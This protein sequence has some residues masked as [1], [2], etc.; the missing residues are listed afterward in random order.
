M[1]KAAGLGDDG[2]MG[3]E[4]FGAGDL[5]GALALHRRAQPMMNAAFGETNPGP[6]KS[7]LDLFGID[8]QKVLM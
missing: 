8:A 2:G 4:G 1:V 6:M 7:V 5:A 3:V